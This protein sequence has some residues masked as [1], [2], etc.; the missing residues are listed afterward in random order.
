[1]E[2]PWPVYVILGPAVFF[3][4]IG[5]LISPFRFEHVTGP[6][7]QGVVAGIPGSLGWWLVGIA[8]GLSGIS[9][10]LVNGVAGFLMVAALWQLVLTAILIKSLQH[11]ARNGP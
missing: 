5:A 4:L 10:F 6:F 9:S 8:S 2:I 11:D 3:A 1:M 7:V